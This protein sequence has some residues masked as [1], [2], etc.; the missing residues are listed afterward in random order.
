MLL[1]LD[2]K[3]LYR[4]FEKLMMQPAPGSRAVHGDN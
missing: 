1:E 4:L 2:A 3:K